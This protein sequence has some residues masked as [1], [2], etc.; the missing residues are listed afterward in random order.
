MRSLNL[1]H[2]LAPTSFRPSSTSRTGS[3]ADGTGSIRAR[4][5]LEHEADPSG[6][7]DRRD[8]TRFHQGCLT[9]DVVRE[10]PMTL[11]SSPRLR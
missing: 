6:R 5:H 2:S 4:G 9:V 7:R 3:P 8:Q 11:S 1:P 10:M